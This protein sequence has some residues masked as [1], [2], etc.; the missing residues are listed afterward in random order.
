MKM[1]EAWHGIYN[2]YTSAPIWLQS[3]IQQQLQEHQIKRYPPIEYLS[4]D[5]EDHSNPYEKS[6]KKAFWW[7]VFW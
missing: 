4:N 1:N 7:L 5:H 6:N 3:Q 2:V